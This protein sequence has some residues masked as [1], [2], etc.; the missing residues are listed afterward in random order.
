[1]IEIDRMRVRQV[2]TR[3]G[4][5]TDAWLLAGGSLALLL[6]SILATRE[7]VS[8]G[9]RIQGGRSA[10]T[11]QTIDPRLILRP[12]M[13]TQVAAVDGLRLALTVGPL[14]PGPNRF[15][16]RLATR[17]PLGQAARVHLAAIMTEMAMSPLRLTM[18]EV[19]RGRYVAVGPLAM[20]GRWQLS[21]RIDRSG[22]ETLMHR[23]MIGVD[24]PQGLL[25]S[26]GTRSR[27]DH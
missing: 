10:A 5:L 26:S 4:R 13:L 15:E 25:I 1:M 7:T 16:L 11:A 21:I 2:G 24:L 23:F 17:G 9:G 8:V 3:P 20:F 14:I 6:L 22:K 12:R 19:R 18:R 27:P